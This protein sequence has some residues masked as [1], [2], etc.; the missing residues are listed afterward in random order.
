VR[1]FIDLVL[2]EDTYSEQQRFWYNPATDTMF[3]FEGKHH[4]N[5]ALSNPT[6]RKAIQGSL[7]RDEWE[8]IIDLAS[9]ATEM[10][11]I[12]RLH[13]RIMDILGDLGYMRGGYDPQTHELYIEYKGNDPQKQ[14]R[15]ARKLMRHF[16]DVRLLTVEVWDGGRAE[17]VM[18]QNPDGIERF[19]KFGST[20]KQLGE[21]D[22]D[23][24]EHFKPVLMREPKVLYR[25]VSLPELVDI[26]ANGIISGGQNKFN[27]FDPR[28]HVFFG[29]EMSEEIIY[30]GEEIDRQANHA[31]QKHS[32][33]N[34]FAIIQR[35]IKDHMLLL[36]NIA[37]NILQKSSGPRSV[38]LLSQ[39]NAGKTQA[40]YNAGQMAYGDDRT[41]FQSELDELNKEYRGEHR[42]KMKE[43]KDRR[44]TFPITS[45]V[46]VTKPIS[47]GLYY[48]KAHGKSGMTGNEYGFAPGAVTYYNIDKIVFIKD[49][50]QVG[51]LDPYDDIKLGDYLRK[52]GLISD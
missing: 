30:Q 20:R 5:H 34:E 41:L 39:V 18:L 25:S 26:W 47:G 52:I 19:R 51:T 6:L 43:I 4:V 31:L 17:H 46:I 28:R 12:V 29:D 50:K 11:Q 10:S 1:Q 2:K 16:D 14:Y 44:E 24:D 48:S 22:S 42:D 15:N 40:I 37:I 9:E 33:H 36:K 32:L 35:E 23:P 3:P 27:S 38:E 8:E 49:G 45:A 21:D 13:N 7:S